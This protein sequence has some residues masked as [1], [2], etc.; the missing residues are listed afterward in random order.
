M[1]S[2]IAFLF[3]GQGVQYVGMGRDFYDSFPVARETF[4]EADDLLGEHLSKVIFQGSEELLTETLNSQ[5]AIFIVSMAL[6]RTVRQQLPE[7]VPAVCGGLSLGEY[8]ALCASGRLQFAEALLLVRKRAHLMSDAC[9]MNLGSMAAVLGLDASLIETAL[10]SLQGVWVANYNAPG[11]TVISGTREG[12]ERASIVLK[13]RGAR[14]VLPLA[15]QGAFH[16]PLMQSAQEGL[17]EAIDRALFSSSSVGLVMNVPGDFVS[18]L[19][20]IKENL[21]QQVTQSVRWEQGLQAMQRAGVD[22]YLEVGC[23]KTLTG[24]N[25][26]MG[27]SV[28]AS[29]EKVGDLEGIYAIA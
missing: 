6:F 4:Q 18:D 19:T 25:R 5:L 12:V 8:S 2:K 13:E 3:P 15:V 14:R 26:K 9:R 22:L 11:Q 17:R 27:L 20:K 7:L 29:I 16:S 28:A 23:G 24:L 10:Q 1:R 21:T